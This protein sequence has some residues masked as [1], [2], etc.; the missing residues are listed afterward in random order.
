VSGRRLQYYGGSVTSKG[1][2]AAKLPAWLSTLGTR[3]AQ[4]TAIFGKQRRKAA[5]NDVHSVPAPPNHV[6]V[7]AYAPGAGIMVSGR[8]LVHDLASLFCMRRHFRAGV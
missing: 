1:L 3:M 7:N 6:L 4:N 2:L 5:G 8:L